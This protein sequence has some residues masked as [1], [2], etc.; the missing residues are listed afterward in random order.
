MTTRSDASLGAAEHPVPTARRIFRLSLGARLLSLLGVMLLLAATGA[1]AAF[2]AILLGSPSRWSLGLLLT[3]CAGFMGALS[4]YCL[5]DLRGKLGLRVVLDGDS[6]TLDLPAGRSLVH[7][8]PAQRLAIPYADVAAIDA[9]FEGY[10]SLGMAMMQRAYVLHRKSGDLVF[11][12][13]E[14]ALATRMASSLFASIIAAIVARTHVAVREL[15]TVEGM[16]GL[17]CVWGTH[18]ADWAAPPL[19]R[20]QALRLWRHAAATGTLTLS[21]VFFLVFARAFG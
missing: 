8:P 14:R 13:E 4:G 17:L 9:R 16:G 7:R 12:F 5:R 21:L 20:D 18:A 3:A 15:G 10:R 1:M 2:A 6:M 11:L 19:P